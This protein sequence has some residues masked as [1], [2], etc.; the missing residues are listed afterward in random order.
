METPNGKFGDPQKYFY[1]SK[2]CDMG[3]DQY[4]LINTIF[5]GMNIHLPAILMWTT[6]VLLVLTHC[7]INIKDKLSS[8]VKHGWIMKTN[9]PPASSPAGK[10]M[11]A[12]DH[13]AWATAETTSEGAGRFLP[14]CNRTGIWA[15]AKMISPHTKKV[16]A[17]WISSTLDFE[18]GVPSGNLT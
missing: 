4:L 18:R 2:G 7:H 1:M 3:M 9:H 15:V 6:G 8:T 11:P 5:R 13:A 14:G 12:S 16:T 17:I 10:T